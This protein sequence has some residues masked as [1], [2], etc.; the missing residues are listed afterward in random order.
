MITGGR[1]HGIYNIIQMIPARI[2]HLTIL[3]ATR[4]HFIFNGNIQYN[5]N[6]PR[7]NKP[8]NDFDGDA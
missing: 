1:Q 5:T 3:M 4:N 8:F 2:N 6:D 7:K